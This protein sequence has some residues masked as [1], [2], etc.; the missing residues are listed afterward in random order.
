MSTCHFAMLMSLGCGRWVIRATGTPQ[1]SLTTGS[2]S[3]RLVSTGMSWRIT[4]I[5]MAQLKKSRSASFAA[6]PHSGRPGATQLMGWQVWEAAMTE[7]PMCPRFSS[8]S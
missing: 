4:P 8:V 5:F 7:P 2:R 6:L 3:T 1:A